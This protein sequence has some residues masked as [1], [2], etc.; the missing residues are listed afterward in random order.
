MLVKLLKSMEI[1]GNA[2]D[3]TP[4]AVILFDA[5]R[6]NL[7]QNI[8]PLENPQ[9]KTLLVVEIGLSLFFNLI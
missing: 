7:L 5:S 4:A 1:I 6:N 3:T 9:T 2:E 8:A